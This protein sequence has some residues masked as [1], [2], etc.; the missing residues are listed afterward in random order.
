[1]CVM[2]KRV[3]VICICHAMC[4]HA[5]TQGGVFMYGAVLLALHGEVVLDTITSMVSVHTSV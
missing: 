5:R 3:N 1:M 2:F 4:L